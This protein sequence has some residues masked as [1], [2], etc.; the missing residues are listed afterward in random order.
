MDRLP[1]RHLPIRKGI[2]EPNS[3]TRSWSNLENRNLG[4][5]N[6]FSDS[7]TTLIRGPDRTLGFTYLDA[8]FRHETHKS[9]KSFLCVRP[10]SGTPF[11]AIDPGILTFAFPAYDGSG[12]RHLDTDSH[13]LPS[14]IELRVV[15]F[16]HG[17][18]RIDLE[19]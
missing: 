6:Y 12:D 8:R 5:S 15:L 2:A 11:H 18:S 17:G 7:G 14:L 16:A 1:F 19:L 10:F 9:F 3:L 13:F 4:G